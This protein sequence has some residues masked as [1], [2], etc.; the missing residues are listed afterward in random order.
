MRSDG[1]DRSPSYPKA[2][3]PQEGRP[4]RETSLGTNDGDPETENP[5]PL[6]SL[7]RRATRRK[8]AESQCQGMRL[9]ESRMRG[10]SARPVRRG[11]DGKGAAMP[12]RR[13]PTR[14]R[15]ASA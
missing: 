2:R 9:L 5:G 15:K 8:D 14:H 10:N 12:P 1:E 4:E 6:P 11:V 3:G 13:P 7:P